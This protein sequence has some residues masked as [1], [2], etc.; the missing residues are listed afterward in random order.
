MVSLFYRCSLYLYAPEKLL[1]FWRED[2][3]LLIITPISHERLWLLVNVIMILDF[4][5][6]G[7][8]FGLRL[9]FIWRGLVTKRPDCASIALLCAPIAPLLRLYNRLSLGSYDQSTVLLEIL[10][11]CT[12]WIL[13]KFW[14]KI[15]RISV[16]TWR[17]VK[18][19]SRFFE[20]LSQILQAVLE[21]IEK[22]ARTL[23]ELIDWMIEMREV[24]KV[25]LEFSWCL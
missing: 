8:L 10:K 2:S 25:W 14:L 21:F 1:Q 4:R 15:P 5:V 16:I 20:N 13:T 9:N 6:I 23:N 12:S 18:E 7:S 22:S 19:S 3:D 24:Y 11:S 17:I